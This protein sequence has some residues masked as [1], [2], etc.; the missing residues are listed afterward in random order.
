[1]LLPDRIWYSHRM[2]PVI[3]TLIT[4]AVSFLCG[5]DAPRQPGYP[6]P[7]LRHGPMLR[8]DRPTGPGTATR[9]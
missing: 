1:M 3:R 2:P 8:P 4:V 6:R 9:R 5:E 7:H